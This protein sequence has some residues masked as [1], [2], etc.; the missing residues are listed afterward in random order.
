VKPAEFRYEAPATLADAL[1]LLAHHGEDAKLLAGGQSL[2]PMMSFR[3]ARP[4]V[5]IDLNGVAGLDGID[6]S[7]GQL[8][9]G[10][11]VRH[12]TL[13]GGVVA[14]P[15]GE[16]LASAGRHVGHLPIRERGTFGG[17]LAHADPAAEW[18]LVATTLDA[19][20]VLASTR[21]ERTVA[22]DE[23]FVSTFVT[24]IA[25][26]E[27]IREVRLPLLGP[28]AR[29]AFGEFSRRE[30]D[31]AMVAVAVVLVI[32]G[33][34]I[35]TARIGLGGVAGRPVRAREAEAALAGSAPTADAFA[36][37]AALAARHTNPSADIHGSAEYRRKVVEVLTRRALND[38]GRDERI[39][40]AA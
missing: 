20:F 13:A 1:A 17:S 30:G 35:R 28:D 3:L 39:S 2:V 11:L 34:T 23:F 26:D 6:V 10:G 4:E 37:A 16:L 33:G 32:D 19:Q 31:F 40:Y 21:G 27:L 25:A 8:R 5:L 9:V 18:C 22:A 12:A 38:A 7:D 24:T 29:V 14:D 15:V 36:A